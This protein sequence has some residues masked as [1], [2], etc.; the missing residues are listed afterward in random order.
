MYLIVHVCHRHRI[1]GIPLLSRKVEFVHSFRLIKLID[2]PR[3]IQEA[4]LL[5]R[6]RVVMLLILSVLLYDW[7]VAHRRHEL[8][9]T[10]GSLEIW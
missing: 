4:S 2:L 8:V 7:V 10:V 5:Q 3:R 1:I 9:E 6:R